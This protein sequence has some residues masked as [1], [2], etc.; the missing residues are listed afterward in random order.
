MTRRRRRPPLLSLA[1]ALAALLLT[2]A[3][4]STRLRVSADAP[5]AL[6]ALEPRGGGGGS[7]THRARLAD[8]A[9]LSARVRR[10]LAPFRA[11]SRRRA[12]VCYGPAVNHSFLAGCPPLAGCAAFGSRA[13]AEAA[14]RRTAGCEGLTRRPGGPFELRATSSPQPSP[15]GEVSFPA[16][17]CDAEGQP[18]LP[19]ARALVGAFHEAV[20]GAMA[21]PSLHFRGGEALGRDGPPRDDDSIFVAVSAYRDSTCPHTVRRALARADLPARVRV[22]VV[23]HRCE[24]ECARATGWAATRAIVPQA[25]ADEDCIDSFCESPEGRVHCAA[26]R[27]E[28]LRLSEE[29]S[30]GPYFSRF[31]GS[32]LW[33]G[34]TF[35]LQIDAHSDFRQGWDTTLVAMIKSTRT[36]P[37]SLISNY[38]PSGTPA[39]KTEWARATAPEPAPPSLCAC[40]FERVPDATGYGRYTIRLEQQPNLHTAT[41]N[42]PRPSAFV[43]AGFFFTH[44]S[45]LS[46]IPFDPFMPFLFM[47]EEIAL[48]LRFWTA[49]FDIYSP[50]VS[51][52][53]H[54]Y[55]RH[56]SIKF[57]ESV[58]LT[59]GS[60]TLYNDLQNLTI[61]RVQHLVG[62]SEAARPEQV[63]PAIL[64]TQMQDFGPGRKRSRDAFIAH[65]RL[66]VVRRVQQVPGWCGK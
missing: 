27:V 65:T 4:L 29:E 3:L 38:P 50:S 34:E 31:L 46:V 51:V 19:T 49:G 22:G 26:G 21:E 36:Y 54:E 62:F 25:Y 17:S 53:S 47:G 39:S 8:V 44:A 41:V 16:R 1:A 33:R 12:P 13:D 2:L 56:H 55:G 60:A 64:L 32:H 42:S 9:A 58:Q 30:F 28:I 57:W 5:P 10:A 43:A 7:V 35:Y 66:D 14:C 61:Q 45:F 37:F 48:S 18:R 59:Y 20:A 23:Q 40:T 15:S 11:R 6:R 52:I 63:E 24:S